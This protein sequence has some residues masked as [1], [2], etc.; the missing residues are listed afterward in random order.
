MVSRKEKIQKLALVLKESDILMEAL[1]EER[2][3]SLK[4]IRFEGEEEL[5]TQYYKKILTSIYRVRNNAASLLLRQ[6]CTCSVS[7]D[8]TKLHLNVDG[9]KCE[10]SIPTIKNIL[11]G[12]FDSIFEK[13]KKDTPDVIQMDN[14]KLFVPENLIATVEKKEEAKQPEQHSKV[15]QK[16]K[17]PQGVPETKKT[18]KPFTSKQMDE[19]TI[20]LNPL[21]KDIPKVSEHDISLQEKDNRHGM[22]ALSEYLKLSQEAVIIDPKSEF[23][24]PDKQISINSTNRDVEASIKKEIIKPEKNS[25]DSLDDFL[26]SQ[27]EDTEDTWELDDDLF[28]WEEKEDIPASVSLPV[29]GR[30]KENNTIIKKDSLLLKNGKGTKET[31]LKQPQKTY[32]NK[33]FLN[34]NDE[35]PSAFI[36]HDENSEVLSEKKPEIEKEILP[37]VLLQSIENKEKPKPEVKAANEKIEDKAFPTDKFK[38]SRLINEPEPVVEEDTGTEPVFSSDMVN[39]DPEEILKKLQEARNS[40]EQAEIEREILK[41][42]TTETSG[43]IVFDLSTGNTMAGTIDIEK[44]SNKINGVADGVIS[45]SKK[46]NLADKKMEFNVGKTDNQAAY[47][48]QLD[49]DYKRDR[50][51]FLYDKCRLK[52]NLYNDQDE[53][54]KTEDAELII[55]PLKIPES[56]NSLVTDICAYLESNGESHIAAVSPGGKTTVAIK[57]DEYAVFI[58]GYWENGC[59]ITSV[60]VV[61]VGTN[62]KFEIDKEEVRPASLKNAGIGHNVLYIDHITTIHIIPREPENNLYGGDNVDFIAAVIRDYGIDQ[63]CETIYTDHNVEMTI[64]GERYKY[65][66]IGK[67]SDNEFR[68]KLMTK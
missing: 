48:I 58:R 68:L 32:E 59:F 53:F 44:E 8:N 40:R 15:T 34:D 14:V 56:G 13:N 16:E 42:T 64:K 61:G 31:I 30:N 17:T 63:D 7:E 4:N 52:I 55:F 36:W 39:L 45:T 23:K 46:D 67:W 18:D 37:D 1:E 35:E 5:L 65:N 3:E 11:Q 27:K 57:S 24:L 10:F 25:K 12:D 49:S 51:S 28:S 6:N 33:G 26:F 47:R 41:E 50:T 9:R 21:E 66:L 43:G 20:K 38:L 62:V 29:K 19:L 60:S 22:S 2:D 54:I